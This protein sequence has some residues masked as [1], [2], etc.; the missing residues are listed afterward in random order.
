MIFVG[1]TYFSSDRVLPRS[2]RLYCD[3]FLKVKWL[4]FCWNQRE[5]LGM[6]LCGWQGY[7][8]S[9]NPVREFPPQQK[10]WT[11][12]QILP[13]FPR[14]MNFKIQFKKTHLKADSYLACC[15]NFPVWLNGQMVK[16][17]L[18]DAFFFFSSQKNIYIL[19]TFQ[20]LIYHN[21]LLPHTGNATGTMCSNNRCMYCDERW[22]TCYCNAS[23]K[24]W[25][26]TVY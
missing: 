3:L 1:K 12:S 16:P 22:C 18:S 19:K 23:A 8:P 17:L 13:P 26:Q 15:K 14:K 6:T 11:P 25:T 20:C 4:V 24:K 2:L 5:A 7:K 10:L 9:I 21:S